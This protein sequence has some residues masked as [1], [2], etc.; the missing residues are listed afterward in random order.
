MISDNF[1]YERKPERG[2]PY[3]YGSEAASSAHKQGKPE[4]LK[5]ASATAFPFPFPLISLRS[6][7]YDTNYLGTYKRKIIPVPI[8][9]VESTYGFLLRF[10]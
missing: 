10:M 9:G 8:V 5:A 4:I 7:S 2:I 3:P 6:S 1:V